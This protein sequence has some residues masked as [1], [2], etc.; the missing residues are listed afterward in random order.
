MA[1]SHRPKLTA[2][3]LTGPGVEGFE[4]DPPLFHFDVAREDLP[5]LV[6]S[7]TDFLR[8]LGLGPEQGIDPKST[9]SVILSGRRW[10]GKKWLPGPMPVGTIWTYVCCYMVDEEV[11]CVINVDV[12]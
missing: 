6:D 9:V 8:D 3:Q 5:R 1:H 12:G 11:H 2:V 7:P 10:N 4:T